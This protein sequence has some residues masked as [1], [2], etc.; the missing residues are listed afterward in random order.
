[1]TE[2]AKLRPGSLPPGIF[3]AADYAAQAHAL[4]EPGLF[5]HVAG[6]AGQETTL[7]ANEAAYAQLQIYNR[8]LEGGD[9]GTTAI[10]IV[11]QSFAHPVFLAPVAHQ[12]LLHVDGE[13]ATARAASAMQACMIASTLSSHAMEDIA[14]IGP[15]PRWFQLY[16]Q[17]DRASTLC[18]VRRAEAA[19]F[20]ALV[21]TVDAPVQ[22]QG[23]AAARLGF[24]L[25]ATCVAGN[26]VDHPAPPQ[27]ALNPDQSLVFQGFMA[28][29]PNWADVEWLIREA[30]VPVL[31]KGITHPD[32]AA[33]A[34]SC[35]A[36]GIV[37]SNH[38]GRA[39]DGAPATLHALPAIRARLGEGV[40][41]LV[42]GGVRSGGDIFKALASGAN[43]VLVGRLQAYALAVAGAVGV[44]HMIKLLRDE[45]EIAMA[46]AGTPTVDRISAASL[47][48]E[49]T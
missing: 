25:P 26:L 21:A 23:L 30:R 19:G 41:I 6:G 2:E 11:G 31:L 12:T 18:L 1:M 4:M 24:S 8:V 33:R 40:S 37:V 39:L 7:C 38:G 43:A 10:Q 27:R 15:G 14:T 16:F 9:H 22:P 46:L 48:R 44:A 29:A 35:G 20:G 17:H 34:M 3:C 45:L 49:T 47:F 32:D 36:A 42:D 13:I 5:A 28:D